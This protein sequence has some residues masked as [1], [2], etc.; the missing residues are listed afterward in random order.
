MKHIF[1]ILISL[2]VAIAAAVNPASLTLSVILALFA[3]LAFDK[4]LNKNM[5]QK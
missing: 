4:C 5:V 1:I 3:F 2:A